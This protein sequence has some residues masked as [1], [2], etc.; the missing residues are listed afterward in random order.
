MRGWAK[1]E[2][3]EAEWKRIKMNKRK[4]RGA[5]GKE[6]ERGGM[7]R[8]EYER[9]EWRGGEN[10][11]SQCK[12]Q[13]KRECER[14]KDQRERQQGKGGVPSTTDMMWHQRRPL[15]LLETFCHFLATQTCTY[16]NKH[17]PFDNDFFCTRAMLYWNFLKRSQQVTR[18]TRL[19]SFW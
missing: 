5:R 16:G 7:Q 1:G 3:G 2:K 17:I 11:R 9:L 10:E 14:R 19:T 8:S 4:R 18:Y 12:V 15:W 6:G 13:E